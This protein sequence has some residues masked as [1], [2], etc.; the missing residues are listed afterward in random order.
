MFYFSLKGIA[1]HVQTL[2]DDWFLEH[3]EVCLLLL[4][5]FIVRDAV[6]IN[7]LVVAAEQEL[8]RENFSEVVTKDMKHVERK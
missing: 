8:Y 5:N 3:P 7:L 6:V 4:L 1:S 2:R